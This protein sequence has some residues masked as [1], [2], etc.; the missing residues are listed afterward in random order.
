MRIQVLCSD[1]S[2]GY[3]EDYALDDLISMGLVVA[4]FRPGSN[5]WVDVINNRIRKKTG[6]G[7]QGVE[8]RSKT[9]ISPLKTH[10]L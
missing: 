4:F 9:E 6:I 7:Y 8:R 5:E 2:R 10:N 1:Q 3:V